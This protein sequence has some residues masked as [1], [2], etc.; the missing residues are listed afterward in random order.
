[1]MVNGRMKKQTSVLGHIAPNPKLTLSAAFAL[2]SVLSVPVFVL[3]SL[4]DW[5]FL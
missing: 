4:I 5:L 2:A 1:M 3:L